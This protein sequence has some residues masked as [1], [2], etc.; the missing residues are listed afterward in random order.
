M[1]PPLA[2]TDAYFHVADCTNELYAGK[3]RRMMDAPYSPGYSTLMPGGYLGY[4]STDPL[5]KLNRIVEDSNQDVVT[6]SFEL[7]APDG[8]ADLLSSSTRI[9]IIRR[10]A[11]PSHSCGA[12]GISR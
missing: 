2:Q 6:R 12:D 3:L 8:P 10:A 11:C 7:S 5:I 4:I 9:R 1:L